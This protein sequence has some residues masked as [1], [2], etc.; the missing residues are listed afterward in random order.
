[1]SEKEM[2]FILIIPIILNVIAVLLLNRR[3]AM[4]EFYIGKALELLHMNS[5]IRM[6]EVGFIQEEIDRVE[7]EGINESAKFSTKTSDCN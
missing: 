2:M 3:V 4:A 7:A 5:Q 6:L 1:M